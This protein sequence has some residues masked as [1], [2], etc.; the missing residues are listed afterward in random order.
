MTTSRNSIGSSLRKPL[1]FAL[2]VALGSLIACAPKFTDQVCETAED[3][4]PE[5][6]CENNQ[7]VSATG[8]PDVGHD[9]TLDTTPAEDVSPPEDV[10]DAGDGTPDVTPPE[11][12]SDVSDTTS[13]ASDVDEDVEA[14]AEGDVEVDVE[15]NACDGTAVLD[16]EPGTPCGQCLLDE[17]ICDGTDDTVCNGDTVCP[18]ID[19]VALAVEDIEATTATLRGEILELPL[20]AITAHGFCWGIE[21]Q[22]DETD[23]CQDLAAATQ[24]GEF[25]HD[26]ENL[27]QGR[28]YYVRVFATADGDTSWS[29][30][31]TFTTLAPVPTGLSAS[32][33][34]ESDHVLLTWDAMPGATGY[35]ID[36]DTTTLDLVDDGDTD[37][38]QD[39]GATSG[40]LPAPTGLSTS[41]TSETIT[42]SWTAP[43]PTV[44]PTH[45]YTI[46]AVY[47]DATSDP[48][49]NEEGNTAAPTITGYEVSTDDGATWSDEGTATQYV[50]DGAPL[51]TIDGGAASASRAT[52]LT[53]VSLSVSGEIATQGAEVEYRVRAIAGA[54]E[55]STAGPVSA[56]LDLGTLT[57]QWQVSSGDAD[58]DYSTL[59][60]ATSDEDTHT[61]GDTS[62][63]YYRVV[64]SANGATSGTST[65]DRGYLGTLPDA[66]TL[67]ASGVTASTATLNGRIEE[68]GDPEATE[69]GFCWGI[70]PSP[71]RSDTEDTTCQELGDPTQSSFDLAI[72]GLEA[73]TT[74]YVRSFLINDFDVVYGDDVT[75]MTLVCD[76]GDTA[77]NCGTD[78][79]ECSFGTLTCTNE[80]WDCV[81]AT[82]PQAEQC[83]GL[84][85]DCD[86]VVDNGNP[87]ETG[88]CVDGVCVD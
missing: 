39:T 82:G 19:I 76:E 10:S 7:C 71:A 84:D 41:T 1:L 44:G 46:R 74:Y 52:S 8:G 58:A 49:A 9:A 54:V 2:T 31:V 21:A 43:T 35:L 47:P 73:D 56:R 77:G 17:F 69:H 25:T 68:L 38:L 26:A 20:E 24:V 66:T 67:A 48:S 18:E 64:V 51:G 27:D 63:R 28:T 83:N 3:C 32:S 75:F 65:A 53:V 79:G 4:F 16:P 57:Y 5:E 78:D 15:L 22:P 62:A 40:S 50:D 33:G 72:T 12:V 55:G 42:L 30:Q 6:R 85:D 81:G 86:G 11:D 29:N 87:C 13:D 59:T 37:S 80:A 45:D 60:G 14:D 61:P 70:A 36:R 34:T 23:D 88:T